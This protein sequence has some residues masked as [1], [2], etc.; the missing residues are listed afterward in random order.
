M[1]QLRRSNINTCQRTARAQQWML[2]RT[3]DNILEAHSYRTSILMVDTKG[4]LES[5]L[6]PSSRQ[7]ETGATDSE[8]NEKR[9]GAH[10]HHAR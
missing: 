5:G 1:T 4:I 9:D 8:C 6:L 2:V 3:V 7:R 10:H